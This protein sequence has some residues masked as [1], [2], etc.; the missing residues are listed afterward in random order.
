MPSVF[1]SPD[2]VRAYCARNHITVADPPRRPAEPRP[3][4]L[5]PGDVTR[6]IFEALADGPRN[7]NQIGEYVGHPVKTRVN[8]LV[9]DGRLRRVK[10]G[11][12]GG[13]RGRTRVLSL[14]A[15]V[16]EGAKRPIRRRVGA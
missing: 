6:L 12:R 7:H 3:D 11:V 5:R 16:P 10:T 2:Q 8:Q 1:M 14:Y 13:G 9:R 4:Y 15:L